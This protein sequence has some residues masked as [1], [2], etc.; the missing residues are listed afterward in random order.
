M[1]GLRGDKISPLVL[2]V[3]CKSDFVSYIHVVIP[4][5][6]SRFLDLKRFDSLTVKSSKQLSCTVLRLLSKSDSVIYKD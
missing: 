2:N 1:P 3:F 4:W 5:R 6:K